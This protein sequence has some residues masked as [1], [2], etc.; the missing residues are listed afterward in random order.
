MLVN[1]SPVDM[2]M[3]TKY[4]SCDEM[5]IEEEIKNIEETEEELCLT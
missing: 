3:P 2:P 5:Q 1:F 4:R